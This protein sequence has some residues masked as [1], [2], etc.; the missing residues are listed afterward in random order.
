MENLNTGNLNTENLNTKEPFDRHNL[1]IWI[2]GVVVLWYVFVLSTVGLFTSA[3]FKPVSHLIDRIGYMPSAVKF[4]SLYLATLPSFIGIFVYCAVTKRNR[5][6]LRSFIAD[7]P[8]RTM[9]MLLA[10]LLVGFIMNFGCIVCA[11]INGDIHL[12]LNF[13]LNQIPLFCIAL[14]FVFIQSSSEEL[15]TRGFMYERVNVRYPLWVAI[16]VNGIFFGLLHCFNDGATVFAI[17][18]ICVCG[19]SFSIAKW[20]TGSIWFPAGIHTAWNFTQNFLF[21][22]PNSGIVSEASIFGLDA[23]TAKN[24]LVYSVPFGVEGAIPALVSDGLL[25]VVCLILAIRQGRIG[26]LLQR[27]V[28]PRRDPEGPQPLP[29]GYK[30]NAPA[31][32]Y[33]Y[34]QPE[35]AEAFEPIQAEAYQPTQMEEAEPIQAEAIE[36]EQAEAYQPT[37]AEEPEPVQAEAFEPSQTDDSQPLR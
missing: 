10:G 18:E 20:Y 17:V 37:Q 19:L 16:L 33:Q 27:Q 1:I 29:P 26:E 24:S 25:G 12:F 13:A 23:A 35:Q 11:L 15:W 8:G 3:D 31:P 5:F 32:R 21:G 36:P 9:K 30:K 4:T 6:V 7:P 2:V 22:L 34:A 28:T 14:V